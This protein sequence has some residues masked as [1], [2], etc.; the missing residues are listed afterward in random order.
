MP[1]AACAERLA[2]A[3][4]LYRGELAAGLDLAGAEVF[5]EWLT[6]RRDEVRR[7]V[8]ALWSR[9]AA[10]HQQAQAPVQAIGF[11][12]RYVDLAPFDEGRHR[13]LMRQLASVGR[14]GEA[15]SYYEALSARLERELGERPE[16]ST[17]RLYRALRVAD[18]S[19]PARPRAPLSERRQI[20]ALSCELELDPHADPERHAETMTRARSGWSAQAR[21]L[22]GW[23]VPGVSGGFAVYFGYPEARE[24]AVQLAVRAALRIASST[25]APAAHLGVHTGLT[26][27]GSKGSVP[28]VA[29]QISAVAARI[30]RSAPAGTVAISEA[31][32]RIAEGAFR[33]APLARCGRLDV[34]RVTGERA[35]RAS[36]PHQ[37]DP[38]PP[39]MLGRD[40]ELAALKRAWRGAKRGR[41]AVVLVRGEPGIGK[42]RLVEAFAA[43]L[44]DAA[45]RRL[46][47]QPEG[48][49]TP[50]APFAALHRL[51]EPPEPASVDAAG[52]LGRAHL[53]RLRAAGGERPW[54]LIV[55]DLQWADPSSLELLDRLIASDDGAPAML[56]LTA[57]AEWL[58]PWASSRF[59]AL[60]LGPLDKAAAA[61]LLHRV[62]PR[63][64]AAAPR[65]TSVQERELLRRSNGVP[66]FIEALA[67]SGDSA[68]LGGDEIPWS[69]R[70]L[71]AAR[72]DRV[73]E[74]KRVARIAATLGAE[75]DEALL[76]ACA[77]MPR[78]AVRSGLQRLVEAGL[79]APGP[80]TARPDAPEQSAP[81]RYH[82]RHALIREAAYASQP[83]HER[84]AAHA[85]I[86]DVLRTKRFARWAAVHP[87][88]LARHL[89]E[90]GVFE[91]AVERWSEAGHRA[92]R[93]GA[94]QEAAAHF[95][96]ALEDLGRTAPTPARDA[97]ALRLL[98]A[99]GAPLSSTHG[100]GA[101]ET[102]QTFERALA[103][104]RASEAADPLTFDALWGVWQGA[105]SRAGYGVAAE[106]SEKL[107]AASAHQDPLRRL[108][109]HYA[110]GHV[111]FWQGRFERART[112]LERALAIELPDAHQHLVGRHAEDTRVNALSMLG[113][114]LFFLGEP[115]AAYA[116]CEQAV[117][118]AEQ[119]GH[120]Y[121]R[122]T[123]KVGLQVLCRFDYDI[124]RAWALADQSRAEAREH[125]FALW[126]AG[127]MAL[128]GWARAMAGDPSG[129][130]DIR[131]SISTTR[132][133]MHGVQSFS[134]GLLG[135]ALLASERPR[136][137][138]EVLD[139]ARAVAAR[140]DEHYHDPL[141]RQLRQA[142][143]DA[144]G[145][146]APA[147]PT[148][149]RTRRRG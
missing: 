46:C 35:S 14:R 31:T 104:S 135:E 41:R 143:I 113:W 37:A 81:P 67:Q 110:V 76:C 64:S 91:A 142:A 87:E 116:R 97:W 109:A 92:V 79:I 122:V 101:A 117:A 43:D 9:L 137:A 38:D 45:P 107:V 80:S 125:G 48:T 24:D 86:A 99:R 18:P 96:R 75:L 60:A 123:A 57:R 108:L 146:D 118:L 88:A 20:T 77:P 114:T 112:S 115:R 128:G 83:T 42:S 61:A 23:V 19:R 119:T 136:E 40:R 26:L 6:V 111:A 130:D 138:L 33:G 134:L 148:G 127:G 124:A 85:R 49:H 1:C 129:A 95:G 59:T 132:A 131:Q 29:G 27:L 139:E 28:E 52:G 63:S 120:P 25:D 65:L 133:A 53:E 78:A 66:L 90:A 71:L 102:R 12:Q 17:Q 121:S 22:G 50:F 56:L 34:F 36:K 15:L 58:P 44:V 98:V 2:G 55:E 39:P 141:F 147:S 70:D 5:A 82:F 105:S 3:S 74:A 100:Y 106:L 13:R 8:L 30:G 140:L 73:G 72:L 145:R 68:L 11:L 32:W 84:T 4:D 54:P 144:L 103:L 47:C 69:L 89:S 94:N 10:F 126:E 149:R 51:G 16:S 21:R 7:K 93:V 62:A